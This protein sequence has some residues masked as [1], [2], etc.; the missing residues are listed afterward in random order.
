MNPGARRSPTVTHDGRLWTQFVVSGERV[1]I[2]TRRPPPELE[3]RTVVPEA[4]P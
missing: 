3:M 2:R 1:Y 4:E